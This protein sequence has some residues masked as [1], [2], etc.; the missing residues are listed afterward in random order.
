MQ[1]PAA[2]AN[3][4]GYQPGDAG[5]GGEQMWTQATGPEFL[6]Q[7][8]SQARSKL[9]EEVKIIISQRPLP[10]R[11]TLLKSSSPDDENVVQESFK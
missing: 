8:G 5:E 11:P 3:G 6:V 10:L 9:E 1:S 4:G 7:M 2:S